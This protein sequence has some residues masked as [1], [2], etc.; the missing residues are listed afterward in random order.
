MSQGFKLFALAASLAGAAHAA[1]RYEAEAAVGTSTVTATS[2]T[3]SGGSYVKM[4][5]G[6]LSFTVAAATAATYDLVVHYAQAY[7]QNGKTQNLVLNGTASGSL[8][9]P[10]SAAFAD[11]K[12]V[13]KLKAGSNTLA[14]TNSWGWVDVDYIELSPHTATPFALSS[15]MATPNASANARKVFAFM[16]EKFQKKVISGVMTLDLLSGMNALDLHAQAEISYIKGASGKEP[17]LVGFDFMHATGKNSDQGWYKAYSNATVTMATQLWKEGGIPQFTW[18]WKDPLKTIESFY[19][20]SASTTP[21]TFNF[22]K[23]FKDSTTCVAWDSTSAEFKAML[24]DIDTIATYLKQLQTAGVPVLWRPIHEASGAWFWW[25]AHGSTAFKAL[26]NLVFNRLTVNHGLTNLVWVWNTDGKDVTWYPGESKVDIIGRDYYYPRITNH[27]SLLSEFETIKNVFGTGKLIA[28]SE[29][30]SV[31]Y[32][33]SLVADAAGWSYFMPWYGDYVTGA[34]NGTASWNT[35]MNHAYVITLSDM[36]GWSNV[37]TGVASTTK[38]PSTSMV[39]VRNGSLELVNTT[40]GEASVELVTLDGKHIATLH[41][42][43]LD[44]GS[45]AFSVKAA[46][47]MYLVRI[48]EA[49]GISTARIALP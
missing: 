36:P 13:V 45:H 22:A 7:D 33:D 29:N 16:Q 41:Q 17:A 37:T 19:V 9:F 43:N 26:Y 14:I 23:A 11:L 15:T 39:R 21:T 6:D 3:A 30:G 48:R 18:H 32:P 42:G 24:G 2:A 35:I 46:K 44:A 10:Y 31:P 40:A 20:G 38:A 1:D 47:G 8:S 25:G 4:Q 12:T 5:G 34:D 28:L 27:G 49:S